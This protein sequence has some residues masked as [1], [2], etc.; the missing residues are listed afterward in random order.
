MIL[1][2]SPWITGN[3]VS[4]AASHKAEQSTRPPFVV[5]PYLPAADGTLA[6]E[7]PTRGPC[8]EGAKQRCRVA[9]NHRRPRSTGPC[10]PLTVARCAVHEKAFTL[11]PPGHVPYGREALTPTTEGGQW[12]SA[13]PEP[14]DDDGLPPSVVSFRGTYF[15]AALDAAQGHIGRREDSAGSSE[16]WWSTQGRR[17][18]RGLSLLGLSA[19]LAVDERHAVAELLAVDT[20]ML[21]EQARQHEAQPGYRQR[22]Q[23]I[24]A[25]LAALRPEA[26][27]CD[28]L[29]E[30]GHRRGLWGAPWRWDPRAGT[31]RRQPY[32]LVD[33]RGSPS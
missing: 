29:A 32:R 9:V 2:R 8:G 24:C 10:I 26:W 19:D 31:L 25:V 33:T 4:M 15:D 28:R 23:A 21:T 22:G 17:L 1:F 13:A 6:P 3:H 27:L 11:Y 16:L 18:D 12:I 5:A 7:L 30:C 14:E 20:L